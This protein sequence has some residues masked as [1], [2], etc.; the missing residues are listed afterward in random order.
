MHE[1]TIGAIYINDCKTKFATA[2]DIS[3]RLLYSQLISVAQCTMNTKGSVV[4]RRFYVLLHMSNVIGI[5]NL[6]WGAFFSRGLSGLVAMS[7]SS[8]SQ[9]VFGE[10]L[11]SS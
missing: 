5:M 9:L 1:L 10:Q 8:A 3:Q 6:L 11:N 7:A 4:S 2:E